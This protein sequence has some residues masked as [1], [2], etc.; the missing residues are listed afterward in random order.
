MTA[1]GAELA[2]ERW[3][4]N[5]FARDWCRRNLVE[6]CTA[7]GFRPPSHVGAHD[8]PTA[9]A[10]VAS[11]FGITV[12]PELGAIQLPAGASP[13]ADGQNALARR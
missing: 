9:L 5:D 11:G 3:V 8:Y 10:G 4:D 12:L 7:A 2:T 1:P 13:V 6:A